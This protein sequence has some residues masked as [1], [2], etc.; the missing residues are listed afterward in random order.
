MVVIESTIYLMDL[1]YL[2]DL[3]GTFVFAISGISVA[4]EKRFDL[5]GAIILALVTAIGGGTLRDILIGKTP[6]GWMTDINYLWVILS[7]LPISYFFLKKI[8]NLRKSLFL[9][10]TIGIGLFTIIGLDKT[11]SAGLSPVV[12]VMMGIVSAVFG[13]VIRDVLSNEI[14][15][16]F[17]K[18]IYASAC[19]IGALSYLLVEYL[20]PGGT[21]NVIFPIL[22]LIG[23]RYFSIRHSW[24]LPFN[25]RY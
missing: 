4:V 7:A 6:V 2:I 20:L 13:G 10:D 17:R 9:F 22:V 1:I 14:P 5:V 24:H 8:Q 11:L 3:V 23:I 21:Y 25:P 16:I 19:L 18:E 15:L 12:A